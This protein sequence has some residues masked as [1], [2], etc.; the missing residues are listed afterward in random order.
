MTKRASP[1][2][3]FRV[4][5][6]LSPCF[7][8]VNPSHVPSSQSAVGAGSDGGELSR[9]AVGLMSH[10][11]V[12]LPPFGVGGLSHLAAGGLLQS[13]HDAM[14]RFPARGLSQITENELAQYFPESSKVFNNETPHFSSSSFFSSSFFFSSSSSCCSSSCGL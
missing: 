8:Y 9:F 14:R 12:G 5:V 6:T 11:A 1:W 2:E 10:L 4:K 13:S 3:R 7:K